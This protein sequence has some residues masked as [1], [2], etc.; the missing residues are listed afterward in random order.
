MRKAIATEPVSPDGLMDAPE[1]RAFSY[2]DGGQDTLELVSSEVFGTSVVSLA[3]RPSG[4][5]DS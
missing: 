1:E 3:Y 5:E 2:S 4:E